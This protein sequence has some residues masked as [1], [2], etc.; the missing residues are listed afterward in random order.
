MN[1]FFKKLEEKLMPMASFFQTQRHFLA[2]RDGLVTAV[3]LTIIGSM[4]LLIAAPPVTADNLSP[5][6]IGI[7]DSFLQAWFNFATKYGD[8]LKAPFRATMGIMALMIVFVIAYSLARHYGKNALNYSVYTTAIFVL[9]VAPVTGGQIAT[10]FLDSKGIILAIMVGLLSVEIMKFVEDKGWTIKMP[11]GVPPVVERS[12]KTLI[13]FT[14]SL[15]ALY[16]IALVVQLSTNMLTAEAIYYMFSKF[17]TA[18]ENVFIIAPLTA[19]ENL[20]FAFGVHPTAVVGPLLDP[21]QLINQGNNAAV[22]ELTRSF[23]GLPH[24]YTQS[25]WAFYVA[26]GGGGA[27]LA[28]CLLLL[29]SKKKASREIGKIAIIPSIF[30]INEPVIFGLPIFLNPILIIPFMIAPTVNIFLGWFATVI[31]LVNP[32]VYLAPWTV[33]A[34]LGAL[35]S[36]MDIKALI[37][38]IV[39]IIIDALIYAPFLKIHEK[40]YTTESEEN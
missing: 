17:S 38:V 25:F 32:A 34:P 31:G 13:P 12:F 22:Y 9:I 1:N 11:K 19:F 15:V 29:R 6:G 2:I 37:L 4:F 39:M 28:L 10:K 18:I 26:L 7:I 30:N 21:L 36:T 24:V 5:S 3:P 20:L 27:T 23:S 33:P 16:S 40:T 35:I 14:I 8:I